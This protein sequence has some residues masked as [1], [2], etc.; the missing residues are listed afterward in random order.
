MRKVFSALILLLLFSLSL[1]AMDFTKIDET[2]DKDIGDKQVYEEL[3]NMLTQ[4]QTVQEKAEV[5]WRLSRVCVDI[6]DDMDKNDKTSRFSIYEEGENYAIQS[7]NL[8]PNAMAYLWK[9]C[10]VGR[11]GQTKGVLNSLAKAKPM[12]ADLKVV[13]DNFNCVDSSEVWYTLGVLYNSLPGVF[14]G[15]SNAA[16]SYGR[17]ACDTI[18]KKFIYGGTYEYLAQMLYDRNWTAKKRASEIAKMQKNWNRESNSNYEKYGYY[19]GA[20]GPDATPIWTPTKLSAMS[21]RQEA[22]VILKYAQAVY[23]TRSFHTSGDDENYAEIQSL[24]DQWSK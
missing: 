21:D 14:G 11:W 18:P 19:E 3:K 4:A 5:L 1:F 6:G 10:N 8:Y 2:Y 9:C 24:I 23:R 16:I 22:L 15:D 17:I 12:M 13:T 20:N 7:I